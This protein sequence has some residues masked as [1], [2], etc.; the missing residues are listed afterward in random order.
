M[1]Q[2]LPSAFGQVLQGA[3]PGIDKLSCF[4]AALDEVP[5]SLTVLSVFDDGAPIPPPYTRDGLGSSPPLT[6]RGVP[7]RAQSLV[8]LVEDADSPTPQPLVHAI[9]W[10]LPGAD[11]SLGEGELGHVDRRHDG[12]EMGRNSYL[13]TAWLPPDPPPGHGPHH[14]AFQL[15]ALDRRLTF[16]HPPG[17]GEILESMREHVLA[18][19]CLI[20][21]YERD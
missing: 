8:I 15:Y 20:G 12:R 11:G 16:D 17:R 19:G 7:R 4:S 1:L 2:R 18:K 21:T 9:A 5:E 13:K 10:N 14:Y 6:W 3:R